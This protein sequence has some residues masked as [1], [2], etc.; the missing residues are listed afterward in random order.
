MLED[1]LARVY[2][3]AATKNVEKIAHSHDTTLSVSR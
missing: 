3:R 2:M 1:I